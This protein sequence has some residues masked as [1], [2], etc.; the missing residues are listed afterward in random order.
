M[1]Y[2]CKLKLNPFLHFRPLDVVIMFL[3]Y[4]TASNDQSSKNTVLSVFK[5]RLKY[6]FFRSEIMEKT[7]QTFT[8]VSRKK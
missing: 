5:E 4:S 2:E 1:Y 8:S 7:F 3:A 6:G